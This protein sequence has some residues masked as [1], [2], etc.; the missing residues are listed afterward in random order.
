MGT[1]PPDECAEEDEADGDELSSGHGAAEDGA[2]AGIA[3]QKLEEITG[4]S[5]EEKIGAEYLAV[6]FL[7]FEQPHQQEK[8]GQFDRGFKELSGFQRHMKRSAG[9][10]GG[11]DCFR[12]SGGA[13]GDRRQVR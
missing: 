9:I 4:N 6:E 5:V 12:V 1:E 10:R 11:I 3:A 7:T 2:A 8:V 13:A